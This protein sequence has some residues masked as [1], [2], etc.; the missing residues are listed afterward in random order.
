LLAG[1]NPLAGIYTKALNKNMFLRRRASFL[2]G[3][4]H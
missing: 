4:R 1:A 3:T 2:G